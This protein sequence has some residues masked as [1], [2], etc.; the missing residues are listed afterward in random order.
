M[1]LR[2]HTDGPGIMKAFVQGCLLNLAD[3]SENQS[4]TDITRL[5]NFTIL[6]FQEESHIIDEIEGNSGSNVDLN[7]NVITQ[8]DDEQHKNAE[9]D[10]PI[11]T[12]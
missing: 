4:S 11:E 1:G 7:D 12:E 6:G 9:N 2:K 10:K 5:K 3:H 8:L